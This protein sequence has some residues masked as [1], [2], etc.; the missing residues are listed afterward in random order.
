MKYIFFPNELKLQPQKMA[1]LLNKIKAF[2]FFKRCLI[3]DSECS[4][5]YTFI[6]TSHL[7]VYFWN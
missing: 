5:E 4:K 6:L 7:T 1:I 2:T 3:S